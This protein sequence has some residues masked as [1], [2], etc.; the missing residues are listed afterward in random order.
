M[1]LVVLFGPPAA[2]K[3]TVGQELARRTGYKLF[4][5]HMSIEPVLD[6][7]DFGTPSFNRLTRQ[8]RADVIKES[9][10]AGLPGL[11]FTLVLALDLDEDTSGVA[12]LVAPVV[13]AGERV[14]FVELVAPLEICLAREG[15]ENRLR[16]KRYKT[17]VDWATAHNQEM[18]EK[19]RFN[20]EGDFPL[21][22]PHSVVENVGS[23]PSDT[24]VK[25]IDLLG[26]TSI[27]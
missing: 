17:D 11:I 21:D 14:D 16:H 15:T 10:V 9:V 4:H 26:L 3:M 8:L 20:T 5:N 7:F 22:F 24:A 1:H 6:V 23:S 25:I 27:G 18:H 12:D 2:G 13:D 19:H